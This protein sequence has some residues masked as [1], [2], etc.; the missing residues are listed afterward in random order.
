MTGV[1]VG[2]RERGGRRGRKWEGRKREYRDSE[3]E[4]GIGGEREQKGK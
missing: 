1:K 2:G 4:I 3:E